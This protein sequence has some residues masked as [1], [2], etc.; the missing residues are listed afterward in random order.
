MGRQLMLDAIPASP[1]GHPAAPEQAPSVRHTPEFSGRAGEYFGIWFV[2]LL[3]GIVTL[4][5]YSAWGKVRTQRYFYGN[6]RLAGA[7][8]DYLASPISILKGRLIAYAVIIALGLSLQFAPVL[9]F[10]LAACI[11]LMMPALICW[12][13]RFRARNSAWRG[14]TF[15]FDE[16]AA[17]AYVP[18]L[19]WSIAAYFSLSLLYPSM[20]VRQHRY[21]VEGHRF[22]HKRFAYNGRTGEYVR[23]YLAMLGL[24]ILGFALLVVAMIA[25]AASGSGDPQATADAAEAAAWISVPIYAGLLALLVY[26]RVRYTNLLWNNASLGPHRFE[27]TLRVR[28]MLWLYASN[29]VAIICTIGLAVPW[30]MVRLARYR[31]SHLAVVASGDLGE[32]FASSEVRHS[33]VGEELVDALDVGLD[34]GF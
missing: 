34:I 14:L 4:G 32:F 24:G 12:S 28:D 21:V 19:L 6:T 25:L 7:T 9:Y 13:L 1:A 3:L 20:K 27:S 18:F 17:T 11:G 30:A 2:N 15:R 23:P 16:S 22:G 5:I 8:F 33:A 10:V 31:A 29:G 26:G